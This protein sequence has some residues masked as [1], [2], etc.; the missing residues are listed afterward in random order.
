MAGPSTNVAA[1]PWFRESGRPRI[2]ADS[3][4]C[5]KILVAQINYAGPRGLSTP[6]FRAVD[7]FSL[8]AIDSFSF[9]WLFNNLRQTHGCGIEQFAI[10]TSFGHP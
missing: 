10:G 1:M 5:R 3:S 9:T 4:G 6:D 2:D 7:S 8:E